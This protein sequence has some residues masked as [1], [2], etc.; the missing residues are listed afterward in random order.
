MGERAKELVRK[1]WV[2]PGLLV[3]ASL[4]VVVYASITSI[5]TS[6]TI[7]ITTG[8]NIQVIYQTTAFTSTSCPTTGYTTSPLGV[9][10]T[11]PAGG[12]AN[13]YLCINNTGT[14]GDTPT[15]AITGGDPLTCG[16]SGT[17]PCF[18]VSP[19]SLP[20]IPAGEFSSPTTLTIS[21][22]FTTAQGSPIAITI[23]VT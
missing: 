12:A 6:N 11:E 3:I 19:T 7:T 16:L 20:K 1:R 13:T 22:S 4:S 18:A 23:T 10:F 14:G 5:P 8:A 15:I 9:S 17:S 21:N 2:L